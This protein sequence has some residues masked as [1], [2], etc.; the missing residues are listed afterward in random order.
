MQAGKD[1]IAPQR[2]SVYNE[3]VVGLMRA[4]KAYEKLTVS[5]ALTGDRDIALAALMAHPLVGDIAKA[6]PLLEEMLEA[7]K[8]YVPKF[9]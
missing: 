7:N 6:A 1:G 2:V 3:Y 5:A 4:V 9:F 8:D